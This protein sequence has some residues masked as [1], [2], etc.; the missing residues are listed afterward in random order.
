MLTAITQSFLV[1]GFKMDIQANIYQETGFEIVKWDENLIWV[2]HEDADIGNGDSGFLAID[3]GDESEG[4]EPQLR[5]YAQYG[6]DMPSI[7]F[8]LWG[9][10][11]A[12]DIEVRITDSGQ[13][14]S[15]YDMASC[16]YIVK[17]ISV[18][19]QWHVG[20]NMSEMFEAPRAV[21]LGEVLP[22]NSGGLEYRLVNS[23]GDF[24]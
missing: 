1:R 19:G 3:L 24:L 14:I 4:I 20:Y 16:L 6:N 21:S 22:I 9:P 17:I 7:V 12:N 8:P 23:K 13:E 11:C 10:V 18:A 2:S 5:I 15:F